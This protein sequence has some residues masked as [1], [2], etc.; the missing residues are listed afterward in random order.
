MPTIG[1]FELLLIGI[2]ALLVLGPEK[3]PGAIK[4]TSLWVGRAR[5][6]FN[7]VKSEIEQQ[8]N[9]DEIRRQ[10][11]N[12]SILADLDDAKK[13]AKALAE[14]ASKDLKILGKDVDKAIK[15]IAAVEDAF[16]EP[17]VSKPPVSEERNIDLTAKDAYIDNP[18]LLDEEPEPINNESESSAL[19]PVPAA[20]IKTPVE[21]FYNNPGVGVIELR[22]GVFKPAAEQATASDDDAESKGAVKK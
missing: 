20:K 7:K 21:D 18:S 9:A 8:L 22:D 11:H 3:L 13:Q 10:L 1:F 6:S 14:D 15:K 17:A 4:T 19:E 2:V 5:R 12:E 16:D